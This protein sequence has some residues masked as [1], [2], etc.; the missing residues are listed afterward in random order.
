[1][2]G[3]VRFFLYR[4]ARDAVIVA[5]LDGREVCVPATQFDEQAVVQ[6]L[7]ADRRQ[8]DADRRRV[9]PAIAR[10]GYTQSYTKEVEW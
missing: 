10:C 7:V 8:L 3:V 9:G 4:T 1:M 2:K 5:D 6:K